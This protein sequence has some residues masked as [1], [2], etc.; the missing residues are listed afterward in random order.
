MN[1]RV[2]ILKQR[3]ENEIFV[4]EIE[5]EQIKFISYL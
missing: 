4:V 5:R 2:R 3:G 1:V